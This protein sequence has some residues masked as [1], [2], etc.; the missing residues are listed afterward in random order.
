MTCM[1]KNSLSGQ[2]TDYSALPQI[3]RRVAKALLEATDKGNG[4]N[5]FSSLREMASFLN[6]SPEMVNKSLV[7]LQ[8]KGAVRLERAKIII[9]KDSLS[10]MAAG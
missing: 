5:H 6:T 3:R 8:E 7:S 9:D 4:G 10:K 1:Q 2:V